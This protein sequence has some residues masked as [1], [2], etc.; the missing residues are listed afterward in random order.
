[1]L[2]ASVQLQ[3]ECATSGLFI[4]KQCWRTGGE[5][6]K[7]NPGLETTPCKKCRNTLGL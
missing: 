5:H 4:S 1:M 6:G 2:S 3:R 7:N